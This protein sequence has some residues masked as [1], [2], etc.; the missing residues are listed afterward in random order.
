MG[1]FVGT[2]T[3]EGDLIPFLPLLRLGEI[4]HLEKGT[5]F[6]LGGSASCSAADPR[7]GPIESEAGDLPEVR[8]EGINL[9]AALEG[10]G[11]DRSLLG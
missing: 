3:F 11:V 4:V 2:V 8:V 6:G 1:G 7:L 5:A 10:Q 9:T